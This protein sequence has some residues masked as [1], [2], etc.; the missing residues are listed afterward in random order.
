MKPVLWFLTGVVLG[1]SIISSPLPASAQA[2]P[3]PAKRLNGIPAGP[4]PGDGTKHGYFVRDSVSNGCWLA[5]HY[6]GGQV[7]LA[8]APEAACQ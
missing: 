7:S 6:A 8:V 5:V 4:L 3:E 1:A 2:Q